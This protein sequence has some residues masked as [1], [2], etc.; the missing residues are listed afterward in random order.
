[1][2]LSCAHIV[3]DMADVALQ[4]KKHKHTH[5]LIRY[6]YAPIDWHNRLQKAMFMSFPWFLFR[7]NCTTRASVGVFTKTRRLLYHQCH[8]QILW[9][10]EKVIHLIVLIKAIHLSRLSENSISKNFQTWLLTGWRLRY[11]PIGHL[12]PKFVTTNMDFKVP[13]W[14]HLL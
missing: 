3:W 2:T 5:R 4:C 11:K 7:V 10:V 1:M 9:K 13:D 8:W 12:V 6:I 14:H